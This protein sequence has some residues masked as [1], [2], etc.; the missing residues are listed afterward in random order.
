MRGKQG[1]LKKLSDKQIISTDLAE[2][3]SFLYESL[4]SYIHGNEKRL[5]SKGLFTGD[6]RGYVFKEDDFKEWC[7]S[8]SQAIYIGIRLFTIH[9]EQWR[10]KSAGLIICSVCHQSDFDVKEEIT[11]G[12][13]KNHHYKCLHCGEEMGL[14]EQSK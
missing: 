10:I 7:A 4:N 13:Q 5:I 1:L 11:L 3:V 6:Y 8:V 2:E 9:L 14:T 12:G